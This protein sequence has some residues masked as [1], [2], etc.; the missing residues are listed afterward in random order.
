M[1]DPVKAARIVRFF[2]QVLRHPKARYR[3][4]K[5][6]AWEREIL[7]NIFGRVD[8]AGLRLI[9]RAYLEMAKKNGKSEVAAGVALYML[10][11]DG[12]PAAEV[13]GAA[14]TREQAGIVYGTAAAMVQ[15]S[16]V[17]SKMLRV[18]RS[19]KTIYRRDDPSSFYRA[20]SADGGAADGIN[21]HCVVIDELHRWRTGRQFELYDVLTKGTVAR[22]QPLVFEITTAGST[23][24]E[25]PLCALEHDLAK[26]V[27]DGTFDVPD[28][29]GRIFAAHP[30]DDWTKP[31]TWAK[32][33]PSLETLGGFLKTSVIAAECEAA[34]N[35]PSRLPS[36]KRYHLG[37][38]TSSETEWLK[39][40]DWDACNGELRAL[41]E[42]PCYLGLDLSS[43]VDLTSLVLL[44][45][46]AADDS[47][48]VL[49]FFWMPRDRVREREL[50]DRVPY[51]T[52]AEEGLLDLPEGNVIDLRT[53]KAK[54]AWAVEVFNVQEIAYDPH[55]ALQLSIELSEE[56]GVKCIPVP[57][58]Y[59]HMSEP[60]KK[61]V[62]I[63]LQRK[64]RHAGNKLLRWNAKCVR[65][66][67]DGGD[68]IKPVKPNRLTSGKRIDGIVALILAISRGMFHRPSVYEHRGLLST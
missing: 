34:I 54:I 43:T 59:S 32:A 60:S 5:L 17:L 56:L 24:D 13:Y 37:I 55:H 2:E 62:E 27:N 38:W 41:V 3:P 53:I 23:E 31:E 16:P 33:N 65:V 35:Q 45:P 28:F 47:F 22:S 44:F 10:V 66:R 61:L 15:A 25:S 67:T 51:G 21:P 29:Y 26:N 18:V 30:K 8:A 36:F 11:A 46:D 1:Y 4:F 57:Q 49:P 64:M 40:E 7:C 42:R 58:R 52:W 20:I 68:N 9:R 14:T 6:L 63:L 12:E 48:D 50:G 19:T 39:T